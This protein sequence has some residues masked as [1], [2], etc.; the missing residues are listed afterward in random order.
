LVIRLTSEPAYSTLTAPDPVGADDA[1]AEAAGDDAADDDAGAD[2]EDDEDE[3]ELHAAA[4]TP[5]HAM[6][7]TAATRLLDDRKVS[8]IS[9][10]AI[11][12]CVTQ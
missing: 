3:E 2:E 1:E 11:A 10:I 12:T 7:S 8:I 4:V 5:R 9:T 6:P